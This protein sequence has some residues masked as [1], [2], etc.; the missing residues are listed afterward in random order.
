MGLGPDDSGVSLSVASVSDVIGVDWFLWV[1]VDWGHDESVVVLDTWLDGEWDY[2]SSL[3]PM[4]SLSEVG[5]DLELV[6]ADLVGVDD[7]L[8]F[9]VDDLPLLSVS[10]LDAV[11]LVSVTSEVIEILEIVENSSLLGHICSEVPECWVVVISSPH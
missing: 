7:P 6:G 3:E 10:V 2:L 4:S 9:D 8:G 11:L 5:D 1:V